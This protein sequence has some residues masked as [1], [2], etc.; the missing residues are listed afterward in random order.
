M[1]HE[2]ELPDSNSTCPGCGFVFACGAEL[3]KSGKGRCWCME[4]PA[5]L[6][7]PKTE[8]GEGG[9]CY[10]PACLEKLR[11]GEDLSGRG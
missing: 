2:I 7:L 4:M 11:Q 1:S 6:P 3:A 5:G 10:C 8:S 9:A